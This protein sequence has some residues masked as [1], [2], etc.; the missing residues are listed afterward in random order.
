MFDGNAEGEGASLSRVSGEAFPLVDDD[1][2]AG[3]VASEQS[4]QRG[5]LALLLP[6]DAGE[7]GRVIAGEVVEGG[8]GLEI[9]RMPE[10][11]L[12][13]RGAVQPVLEEG[14]DG[15]SI[16]T[17]WCRSESEERLRLDGRQQFL[18]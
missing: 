16:S 15:S 17:F 2:C 5:P 18:K 8:E 14:Q 9:E 3:V 11:Q 10:P 13:C 7:I 12:D 6:R 1:L 4:V